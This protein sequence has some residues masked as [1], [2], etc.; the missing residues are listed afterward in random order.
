MDHIR[1]PADYNIFQ[2]EDLSFKE[3]GFER[4]ENCINLCKK[5]GLNMILDLHK[6]LGFSFDDKEK[7]AGFFTDTKYQENFYNLWCEFA[8]KFSK[9]ENML[10]F[11]LLN[12]VTDYE[13]KDRWN[14]IASEC[15]KRI[16]KIVP[17]IKILVGGYYNNA[18][19]AVKDIN[20]PIDNNIVFNF[21][22][23]EPLIF[24]HQ[25]AYWIKNMDINFRMSYDSTFKQVNE[26]TAKYISKDG[27]NYSFMNEN[28][29]IGPNYFETIFAE[30]IKT[31]EEKG[32]AL[33][34]GEYGVIEYCSA[35][36]TKK[37]VFRY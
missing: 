25:G 6:T 2:N 20:V 12:E 5:H 31:T 23:Y 30:A 17:T 27:L 16:R 21:H 22:C 13:Y 26:Y 11:E 15:I 37:M 18:V 34:C 7:E 3:D 4:I 36:D 19:S 1:I 29:K 24:T 33:Y 35:E 14:A 9:Y 32:V 8:R 10:A 28:E